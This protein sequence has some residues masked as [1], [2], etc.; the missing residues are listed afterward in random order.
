MRHGE[1]LACSS[2]GPAATHFAEAERHG[3]DAPYLRLWQALALRLAGANDEAIDV[4]QCLRTA[5][6][7]ATWKWIAGTCAESGAQNTF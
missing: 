3:S 5:A 7:A 4:V 1:R 2:S 6:D